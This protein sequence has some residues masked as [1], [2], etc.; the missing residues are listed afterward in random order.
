M[1]RMINLAKEVT[2]LE[3]AAA[4]GE[5]VRRQYVFRLPP[6]IAVSF[7]RD[8]LQTPTQPGPLAEKI[9]T[10]YYSVWSEGAHLYLPRTLLKVVDRIAEVRECDRE[11]A[12]REVLEKAS[13]NYLVEVQKQQQIQEQLLTT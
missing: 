13:A 7:I 11:T 6:H 9:I 12:I 5:P 3:K 8:C 10:D 4:K 1:P 2:Q